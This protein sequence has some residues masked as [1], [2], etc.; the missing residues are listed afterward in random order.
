VAK[1][2]SAAGASHVVTAASGEDDGTLAAEAN[3]F[4]ADLFLAIRAGDDEPRC[5]YFESAAF[6]SEAGY[7]IAEHLDA[8][9]RDVLPHTGSAVGRSYPLLRETRMA[10]VVCEIV[11]RDDVHALQTLIARNQ[12]VA[13]AIVRGVRRGVERPLEPR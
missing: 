9:L 10:A 6:R 12:L 3:R 7:R 4:A 8:E 2:L 11:P 13:D 1:G 5:A